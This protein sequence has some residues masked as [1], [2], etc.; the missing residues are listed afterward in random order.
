MS[1]NSITLAGVTYFRNDYYE[2]IEAGRTRIAT[3]SSGT[4]IYQWENV[5]KVVV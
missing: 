3:S 1:W 2:K 4:A 5:P